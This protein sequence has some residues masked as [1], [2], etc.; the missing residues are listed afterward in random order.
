M[1]GGTNNL[2]FAICTKTLFLRRVL[3]VCLHK[4]VKPIF[5]IQ[6]KDARE[7]SLLILQMESLF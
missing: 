3:V 6:K 4:K 1:S 5:V 2:K 7:E